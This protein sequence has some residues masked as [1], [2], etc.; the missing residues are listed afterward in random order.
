[1]NLYSAIQNA[2]TEELFCTSANNGLGSGTAK[3]VAG[4]PL[5]RNL[6]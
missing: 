4:G 1:M 2:V 3:V 6:S 5:M